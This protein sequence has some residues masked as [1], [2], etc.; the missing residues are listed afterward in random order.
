MK[1]KHVFVTV[2]TTKFTKLI[3]T[4]IDSQV[5][6]ILDRLGYTFVQVQTGFD[7]KDIASETKLKWHVNNNS[8]I[9]EATDTLTLKCDKYFENFT[10]EIEKADLVISHAGA[11]T[12][13]DVL[14][15]KKP[16]IVVINEDLMGNH[17]ADLAK[18]LQDDGYVYYCTYKTLCETLQKD[19][20]LLKCYPYP[21]KNTFSNYLN[22]CCGFIE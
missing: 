7:P 18:Q 2:G 12:C 16:L 3:E 10:E 11:G 4:I 9:I 17:Q 13:L 8:I 21:A 22:K 15:N 5:I 20:T 14:R 1:S 6:N 19:I